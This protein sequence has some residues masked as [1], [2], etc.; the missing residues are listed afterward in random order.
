MSEDAVERAAYEAVVA[1][2]RGVIEAA[3]DAIISID[4]HG[5]IETVNPPAERI[6]G[7]REAEVIG[8]N[9]RLLM[10]EPDASQHDGYLQRYHAGG[11]PHIIGI[12]R[13]VHGR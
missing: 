2:Y 9:V 7:Y 12:G 3:V 13:E 10:P 1:R 5:V 8:R 11:E 6:F 4:E